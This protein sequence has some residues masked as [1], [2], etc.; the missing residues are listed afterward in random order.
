[1]RNGDEMKLFSILGDSVST[2]EG[3]SEPKDGVY[4]DMARKISARMCSVLDTWWGK[5]VSKLNGEILVNYS[6]SGASV[7]CLPAHKVEIYG[8]SDK[9]TSSLHKGEKSPAVIIVFLGANDW[10]MGVRVKP[11][12]GLNGERERGNLSYF[13]FA[14]EAMLKKLKNNYPNAEIWCMTL[15]VTY[16]SMVQEFSFPD[17][18]AG[19]HISE[20][21][22]TICETAKNC[23][24]R[25][26]DIYSPNDRCKQ[27]DTIDG[28]HFNA[29]GMENLANVIF[30]EIQE[31]IDV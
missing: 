7:C 19:R 25:V 18:I 3:Y 17:S 6:I 8:C 24:C 26:I 14:Y 15:P 22:E 20:Y 2:F 16:C 30:R 13:A 27:F 28:F 1:M 23:G 4:Y 9:S 12:R 5:V 21:C 29:E 31:G 10:G 11:S